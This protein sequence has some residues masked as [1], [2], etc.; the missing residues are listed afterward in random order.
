MLFKYFLLEE[1]RKYTNLF[2]KVLFV[3]FSL[4]C[5]FGGALFILAYPYL[6]QI[7]SFNQL[8][9]FLLLVFFI[10]GISVGS[11]SL[12]TT[13][14]FFTKSKT[15][16]LNYSLKIHPIKISSIRIRHI[17]KDLLFYYLFWVFPVIFGLRL[18]NYLF[19]SGIPYLRITFYQELMVYSSIILFFLFGY[20]LSSFMA[21]I[22]NNHKKGFYLI[23]FSVFLSFFFINLNNIYIYVRDML[24]VP[25]NYL[26]NSFILIFLSCVFLYYISNIKIK[27][28]EK[29]IFSS[30]ILKINDKISKITKSKTQSILV[31][32]QILDFKR[33]FM[34]FGK[35]IFLFMIPLVLILL[36]VYLF[37]N[38]VPIFNIVFL[39]SVLFAQFASTTYTMLCEFDEVDE[40]FTFP[41]RVKD[42][43]LSKV[44]LYYI[45]NYVVIFLIMLYAPFGLV[46]SLLGVLLYLVVQTYSLSVLVYLGGL[47]PHLRLYNSKIF[48]SYLI[49]LLP[50]LILLLVVSSFNFW[51]TLPLLAYLLFRSYYLLKLSFGKWEFLEKELVG[52]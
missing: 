11:Y 21:V 26:L 34:G 36:I 19:A 47:S 23:S 52:N 15:T 43:I 18:G 48:I 29:N 35:I 42:L 6:T 51:L 37:M 3:M 8:M 20:A 12:M 17:S 16:H 44:Y 7:F 49:Y 2:G 10:F 4:I 45:V 24:N 1:Y 13:E 39:F 5:F 40:Y 31:S 27:Y 14:S 25:F 30:S 22:Y 33:S 9:F 38:F 32:K 50:F 41:L 28:V 46:D